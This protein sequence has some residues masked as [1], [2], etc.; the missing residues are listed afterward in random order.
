MYSSDYFSGLEEV[1]GAEGMGIAMGMFVIV[2]IIYLLVAVV[3]I[4]NYVFTSAALFSVGKRRG[5]KLYGMAWVP[6]GQ[7]WLLGCI[8]DQYDRKATGKDKK[9]GRF[10]LFGYIALVVAVIASLIAIL[11]GAVGIGTS[12]MMGAAASSGGIAALIV[13]AVL[14]L[15]VWLFL[16]VWTVFYY[17]ALFK[18]FRSCSPKNSVWMLVLSILIGALFTSICMLCVRKQDGGFEALQQEREAAGTKELAEAEATEN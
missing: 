12:E 7:L 4:L 14:L 8:A 5:L 11:V 3:S 6:V 18:F 10:M 16:I 1:L 17:I 9:L 13:G 2:L 15:L